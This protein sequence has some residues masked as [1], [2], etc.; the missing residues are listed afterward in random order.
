MAFEQT[1]FLEE[2][3]KAWNIPLK[4]KLAQ[5]ELRRGQ[6]YLEAN[7][8]EFA[9][10]R[11]EQAVELDPEQPLYYAY[12]GWAYYRSPVRD[13]EKA[14]SYLRQALQVNPNLDQAHYFMGI[15]AKR[16]EDEALADHHFHKAVEANPHHAQA[17]RELDLILSHQKQ[18]GLFGRLFGKS[19]ARK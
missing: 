8:P 16:E 3:R 18:E 9:R 1:Q 5:R 6:W 14:R 2:K 10:R 7:R 15:I 4:Q 19:S 17:K 12:V 11:F 13:L